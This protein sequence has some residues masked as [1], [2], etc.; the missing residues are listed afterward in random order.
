M[1]HDLNPMVTPHL[2]EKALDEMA[3]RAR[4][5]RL[6]VKFLAGFSVEKNGL[7]SRQYFERGSVEE[8][9]ARAAVAW[10]LRDWRARVPEDVSLKTLC[11]ALAD[12]FDPD[13]KFSHEPRELVVKSRRRGPLPDRDLHSRICSD[14]IVRIKV[15]WPVDAAVHEAA[16]R[17]G[18][19]KTTAYEILETL[20][21]E[22]P[23]IL[24]K[25][26]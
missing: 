2:D 13:P 14:I 6:A 16:K 5:L 19:H 25:P 3:E 7:T 8:R 10:L 18:V 24:V 9:E 21:K 4:A 20:R 17:N 1:Q 23:A 11:F 26:T 15:G 12:L 22:F